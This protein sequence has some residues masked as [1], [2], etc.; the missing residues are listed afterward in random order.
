M[1]PAERVQSIQFSGVFC[2]ANLKYQKV[3]RKHCWRDENILLFRLFETQACEVVLFCRWNPS[4]QQFAD[5]IVASGS[6]QKNGN[7]K[8]SENKAI[9]SVGKPC[10]NCSRDRKFYEQN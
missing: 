9:F 5:A 8:L 3:Y 2:A 7:R 1:A 4:R 10:L 6:P